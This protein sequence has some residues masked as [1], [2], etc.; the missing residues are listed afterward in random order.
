MRC[1]YLAV[2]KMLRSPRSRVSRPGLPRDLLTCAILDK[3][4]RD[5]ELISSVGLRA[6]ARRR[7]RVLLD[8]GALERR[9]GRVR[10]PR[11]WVPE[12]LPLN[13]GILSGWVE[14]LG[15]GG[16]VKSEVTGAQR[17][18]V[19]REQ[20]PALEDPVDEAAASPDRGRTR[21]RSG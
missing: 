4:Q 8:A 20:T 7:S 14:C 1:F 12:T 10:A 3:P 9:A 18:T 19:E 21:P 15:G 11:Y 5:F 16:I 13:S 6:R 2:V 17:G